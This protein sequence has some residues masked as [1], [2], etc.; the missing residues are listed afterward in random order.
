[1]H[2]RIYRPIK[3]WSDRIYKLNSNGYVLIMCP[4]HPKSFLGGFYYEHRLVAEKHIGRIL[5]SWET[6]HH[7][8]G[9]KTDNSLKNLFVC[10]RQEHDLADRLT[11]KVA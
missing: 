6:V 4:E 1:M 9:D 10:T 5:K 2:K 11:L 3:D 8:S 7:I